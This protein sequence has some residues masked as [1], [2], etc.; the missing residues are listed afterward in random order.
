[1]SER[2]IT[3]TDT[4]TKIELDNTVTSTSTTKGATA[5]AVKTAYDKANAALPK[6]GG[7]MTGT[8]TSQNITPSSN[9]TYNLGTSDNRYKEV[10]V[11]QKVNLGTSSIFYNNVTGCLEIL[12]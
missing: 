8:I 9:S 2:T 7:T 10:N 4:D 1:V 3:V 12:A 5:N 11:S 6:A